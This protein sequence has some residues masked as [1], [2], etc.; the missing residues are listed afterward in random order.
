MTEQKLKPCPFCGNTDIGIN[1]KPYSMLHYSF[2]D[3]CG[4]TGPLGL[5]EKDAIKKWNTRV[6]EKSS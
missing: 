3:E 2:C 6:E 4:T 1:R 5:G